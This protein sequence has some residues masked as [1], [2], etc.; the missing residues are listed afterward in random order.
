MLTF[1]LVLKLKC[2]YVYC[3]RFYYSWRNEKWKKIPKFKWSQR[4]FYYTFH[5]IFCARIW[6]KV[7][8]N[9]I[10]FA[11]IAKSCRD[12]KVFVVWQHS[13]YHI[14]CAKVQNRMKIQ[15]FYLL[16]YPLVLFNKCGYYWDRL[17]AQTNQNAF[18]TK[19][20]KE[21]KNLEYPNRFG[22]KF[23]KFKTATENV[24]HSWYAP[25]VKIIFM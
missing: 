10:L 16:L 17:T 9:R 7:R 2:V 24:V 8:T 4:V 12:E 5:R 20:K 21:T 23:F 22:A 14:G 15:H 6:Q 1:S 19:K 13:L 3:A 25:T 11:S 18:H